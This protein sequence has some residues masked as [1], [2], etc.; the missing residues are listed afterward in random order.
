MTAG[1]SEIASTLEIGWADPKRIHMTVINANGE[2]G[3]Q[4]RLREITPR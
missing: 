4:W 2:T 3:Q 1:T